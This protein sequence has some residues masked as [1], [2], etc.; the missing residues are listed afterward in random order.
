MSCSDLSVIFENVDNTCCDSLPF[1]FIC[2]NDLIIEIRAQSSNPLSLTGNGSF[3][4]FKAL[5]K[6]VLMDVPIA[7]DLTQFIDLYEINQLELSVL[8]LAN[9]QLTGILSCNIP[10][11][12]SLNL[13]D[14]KL[15]GQIP[16]CIKPTTA[17]DLSSNVGIIGDIPAATVE[18]LSFLRLFNTG[19]SSIGA[20]SLI[21]MDLRNTNI[22]S[23]D[24]SRVP[25]TVTRLLLTQEIVNPDK[26]HSLN[27]NQ[28]QMTKGH[29]NVPTLPASLTALTLSGYSGKILSKG[30][31][32][33]TQCSLVGEYE[34]ISSLQA[35]ILC[36]IAQCDPSIA[37]QTLSASTLRSST[38]LIISLSLTLI[39]VLLLIALFLYLKIRKRKQDKN[40]NSQNDD[41]SSR[42]PTYAKTLLLGNSIMCRSPGTCQ[43][44]YENA[45]FNENTFYDADTVKMH[46]SYSSSK[47]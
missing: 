32:S 12:D 28:L 2:E 33:L 6:L 46:S 30:L 35:S 24:M 1:N 11:L 38:I 42:F 7:R 27:L 44:S 21:E 4:K 29:G 16:D 45:S 37:E 39:V 34:C 43:R 18:T 15:I 5:K 31:T 8:T 22:K 10:Q 17:L 9:C 19:I 23:I 14:N 20:Y 40:T 41:Q 3:G 36:N 25:D 26:L 13:P 47:F